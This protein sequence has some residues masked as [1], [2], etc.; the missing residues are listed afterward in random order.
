MVVCT[1]CI[2]LVYKITHQQRVF[3]ILFVVECYNSICVTFL[4]KG[5]QHITI[6]H[7]YCCASHRSSNTTV[8]KLLQLSW[9]V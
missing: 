7:P 4:R 1:T 3:N 6:I 9:F 5:V 8:R 2:D